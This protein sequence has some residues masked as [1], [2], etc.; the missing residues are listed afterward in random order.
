MQDGHAL[1]DLPAD[2]K[3]TL[4][5]RAGCPLYAL[6]TMKT[7]GGASAALRMGRQM[8]AGGKP[9]KTTQQIVVHCKGRVISSEDAK[10]LDLGFRHARG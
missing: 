4:I 8:S 10:R 7:A 6:Y 1:L 5:K 3:E 9:V 2:T